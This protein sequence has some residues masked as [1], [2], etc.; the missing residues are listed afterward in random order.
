M[1]KSTLFKGFIILLPVMMLLNIHSYGTEALQVYYR[2]N[3]SLDGTWQI[4]TDPYENGYYDY[5]Y[6][7]F[8]QKK[9]PGKGAYF[10]DSKPDSPSD[11]VE[12]DFDK[13]PTLQVPIP[14]FIT[15]RVPCGTGK[16]S[17]RRLMR[18]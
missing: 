3:I 15:T 7:P 9:N 2:E 5:R 14:N 16:N 11:L 10:T 17:M 13:S 6:D 8:D 1:R 12:Y 18:T 4:I